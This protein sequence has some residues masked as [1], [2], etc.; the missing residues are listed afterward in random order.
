M[1]QASVLNDLEQKRTHFMANL[2]KLLF[3]QYQYIML[4]HGL[5]LE[6]LLLSP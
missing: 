4:G 1:P 2:L 5:L 6:R 3:G